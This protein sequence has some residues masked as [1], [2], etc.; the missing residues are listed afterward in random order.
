MKPHEPT[1]S[2]KRRRERNGAWFFDC[3]GVLLDSN[4]IKTNAF[5]EV[6]AAYGADVAEQVVRHHLANGGLSRFAKLQRLFHEI[7][8]RV[9]APGE[10]EDLLDSFS[11]E[12]RAG[13]ARSA[14]DEHAPGLLQLLGSSAD[15]H[16]ISGGAEDEVR[17][18]LERHGL[19]T[20][21]RGIFGS[22]A[23][24]REILEVLLRS[25]PFPRVLVGDSRLDMDVAGECEV[26]RVFVTHWTEFKGWRD[27]VEERP[28]IVVVDDLGHLLRLLRGDEAHDLAPQ[29]RWIL[30]AL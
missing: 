28:D 1:T 7:L 14:V 17:W 11:A 30:S 24:K 4:S 5:R 27:Y 6:T 25:D 2:T 16:V 18:A 20:F 13:L 19:D 15:L 3:D 9:P 8:M 22:P 26:H 12:S 29:Q 21:F 23:S 10:L